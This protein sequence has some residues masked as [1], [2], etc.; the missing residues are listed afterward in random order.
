MELKISYPIAYLTDD[1]YQMQYNADVY[2]TKILVKSAQ[3]YSATL[4]GQ[5]F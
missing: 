4:V 5:F 1:T 2:I 3:K